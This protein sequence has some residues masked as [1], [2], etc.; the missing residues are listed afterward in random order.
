[1][2]NKENLRFS[3]R[4]LCFLLGEFIQVYLLLF[5]QTMESVNIKEIRNGGCV[6]CRK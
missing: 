5:G 6:K 4:K 1:M 3:V 2:L